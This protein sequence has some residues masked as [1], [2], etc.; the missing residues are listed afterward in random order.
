V[1][2]V[3]VACGD[4]DPTAVG[5]G[6][7]VEDKELPRT[8]TNQRAS[9]VVEHGFG[10]DVARRESRGNVEESVADFLGLEVSGGPRNEF[11]RRDDRWLTEVQRE[12]PLS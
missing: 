4:D 12:R 1:T 3:G 5:I 7:V 10:L 6:Y 9:D 2:K 11:G 8:P